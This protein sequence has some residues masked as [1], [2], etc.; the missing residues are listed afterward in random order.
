MDILVTTTL[1]YTEE[2]GVS[3][4]E[5]R[6]DNGSMARSKRYLPH[7][8]TGGSIVQ[9]EYGLLLS[10]SVSYPSCTGE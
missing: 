7:A 5:L 8:L 9:A 10:G 4:A 2:P 1:I 6:I 3:L